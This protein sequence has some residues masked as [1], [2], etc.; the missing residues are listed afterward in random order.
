MFK[1]WREMFIAKFL[2]GFGVIYALKI[3]MLLLPLIF[4][5]N[6]S[7]GSSFVMDRLYAG[8]VYDQTKDKFLII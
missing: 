8:G 1:R 6:L 5:D 4:S 3:F 2:A 7:L